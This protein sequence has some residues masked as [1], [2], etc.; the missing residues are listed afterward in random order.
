ME[1]ETHIPVRSNA[2]KDGKRWYSVEEVIQISVKAES[3]EHALDII[4][5]MFANDDCEIEY[6][7]DS[8]EEH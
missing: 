4:T 5:A 8:V 2:D 3:K 6:I 1:G 7:T